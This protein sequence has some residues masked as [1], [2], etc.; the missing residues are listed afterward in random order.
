[1][2]GNVREWVWNDADG[3]A[4]TLGGSW[5]DYMDNNRY[6]T[7]AHRMQRF[8]VNGVRL[9]KTLS[10]PIPDQLKAPI[11]LAYTE[12]SFQLPASDEA[13]RIMSS[14]FIQARSAVL[15]TKVEIVQEAALWIAEEA[16]VQYA[17]K[18]SAMFY[19]MRPKRLAGKVQPIIY[20]PA[21]NCCNSKRPNRN[22]LENIAFAEYVVNSGRA[23]VV[24]IWAGSYERFTPID[25]DP[26]AMA[27]RQRRAAVDWQQDLARALDY[28]AT[29][30]DIDVDRAGYF[31]FS[32]GA[33]HIAIT[34]AMEPRIKAAVL[35]SGGIPMGELPH[36][37]IDIVNY[38]PRI[39]MPLL[40]INGRFDHIY[41]YKQSQQRLFALLGTPADKKRHIA[42]E[43]GHFAYPP[44]STARDATDWF[45]KYLGASR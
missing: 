4:L 21:Q 40:M 14:Q 33:S 43:T 44:N 36:P 30:A 8:E 10:A 16:T 35:L 26:K 38:A 27:D 6:A 37:M 32:R 12:S 45:D 13:F 34:L 20:G 41:P 9:M 2:A 29:R 31:G 28:L 3:E 22:A 25:L 11:H 15:D 42:Y 23:L 19:V 39:R 1:M 18:S 17:D 5:S 24:P 7:T